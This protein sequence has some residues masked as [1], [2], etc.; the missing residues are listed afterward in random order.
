MN[1]H[2]IT[3]EEVLKAIKKTHNW[4]SP[5]KDGIHNFWWKRFT[6]THI[7]VSQLLSEMLRGQ[8]EVPDFMTEGITYLLPKTA[9]TSKRPDKYRPITCLPTIY[10]ILTSII[11]DKIYTHLN[12]NNLLAVEQKGCRRKTKGCKE[13][14]I[15]DTII[16]QH[17]K[18][19]K[20]TIHCIHRLQKSL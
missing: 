1:D 5:G 12:Q 11:T 4:K 3:T 8:T 2:S 20:T 13:Q 19:E 14:L 6:S 9:P 7:K 15:I 17:K 10:K 18:R 16:T